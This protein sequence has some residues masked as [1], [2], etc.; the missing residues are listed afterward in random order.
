MMETTE[1][2]IEFSVAVAE[3]GGPH[4][5]GNLDGEDVVKPMNLRGFL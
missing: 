2:G 5:Y 3:N 4:D 1:N